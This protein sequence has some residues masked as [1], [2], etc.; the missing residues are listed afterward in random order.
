MSSNLRKEDDR[1]CGAGHHECLRGRWLNT[2]NELS[3]ALCV[4]AAKDLELKRLVLQTASQQVCLLHIHSFAPSQMDSVAPGALHVVKS[5]AELPRGSVESGIPAGAHSQVRRFQKRTA[6]ISELLEESAIQDKLTALSSDDVDQQHRNGS[7]GGVTS[8]MAGGRNCSQDGS[9]AGSVSARIGGASGRHNWRK[10][11]KA[12]VATKVLA[13]RPNALAQGRQPARQALAQQKQV[14]SSKDIATTS[15]FF[16]GA[17]ETP[18]LRIKESLSNALTFLAMRVVILPET[19]WYQVWWFYYAVAIAIVSCWVEPFQ[20]AFQHPGMPTA[21]WMTALEYV[22]IV[23]FLLDFLFKFVVAYFDPET[24]VLVTAQP[25]MAIAYCRSVKFFLDI[26]G[27]FPYDMLVSAIARRCGASNK[28]ED[29][30]DWLKLMALSRAYRVFDLFHVLDYRMML[31]QGTLMLLR[32]Y[33]YVFFTAHWAACIFFHMAHEERNYRHGNDDSWV[34]RNGPAFMGRPLY[35]QYILSLYFT[36]TIFTSMGDGRLY[37][38]TIV[39]LSV[40]IVYLLFNLFLGAYIIGTVTIMMVR[41][42]EHSKS[43]RDSMTHLV[44]Y[45]RENELPERLYKAMREHLEVHFD[46]AQTA[47]DNVLSIYPTTIRRLV[48]RHLYLQPVRSCYLFKGCKQRFLDALL[49]AARVE[50]FLP[51]VEIMTEGDNVVELLIVMLG[52]CLVSRGG[53]RVGGVYGMSTLGASAVGSDS[54]ISFLTGSSRNATSDGGGSFVGSAVGSKAEVSVNVR[55]GSLNCSQMHAGSATPLLSPGGVLLSPLPPGL[56][57]KIPNL[58]ST[59]KKGPSDALAEIAFFTDGASYETVVGRTPVRVLSLP[60][61]AW[62]LLVQQFPQQLHVALSLVSGKEFV[63]TTDPVL[64][65]QTRDALTHHQMEMIT[66]LDDIRTVAATHTR[67]C[68]EMRTF[69]F[70]NTAAQ[71]DVES[72]RTMLAQGISPNTADYDGRTGLMLAAAKGH[73]E[74]VQLLLDAGADKDKTD[75]FGISALAEAVKNEHDSTIE[76][77]LKYGATLGAGGLTVAAEMCT[78]VYEGDLVKLRRLLR[79]GAPPDACDYDKRSALH[80]AGAE[81]NLAAVKLLVEEGGADPNFQDRWGNTALDEARRVGAAPV[82]A[83]LEGRQKRDAGVT[84]E[85]KRQ[86]AAHEFMS[87]CGLGQVSELRNAGGY[88]FGDE[89]GCVFAGLLL[90]ASKGHTEVVEVLLEGMPSEVLWNHAHVAMMEAARMAHPDTVTAFRRAGVALCDP[91]GTTTATS[92]SCPSSGPMMMRS[93][94]ADLRAAAQQG[95]G[96]VL[97][98]LLAA[99][100]PGTRQPGDSTSPLHVAVEYGHLGVA[101]RLVEHGGAAADLLSLDGLGRTPLQVAE[102]LSSMRPHDL[103]AKAVHEYLVWAA[104]LAAAGTGPAALAAAAVEQWGPIGHPAID[105]HA[106]EVAALLG[107]PQTPSISGGAGGGGAGVKSSLS[108]GVDCRTDERLTLPSAL[109]ASCISRGS[110]TPQL[111]S[112]GGGGGGGASEAPQG[113]HRQPG[114]DPPPLHTV[115]E[116]CSGAV[117]ISTE[118]GNGNLDDNSVAA[119]AD[120]GA[121]AAAGGLV[122]IPSPELPTSFSV[123]D[124]VGMWD[125]SLP[126]TPGDSTRGGTGAGTLLAALAARRG[127]AEAAQLYNA[128]VQHSAVLLNEPPSQLPDAAGGIATGLPSP[129]PAASWLRRRSSTFSPVVEDEIEQYMAALADGNDTAPAAAPAAPAAAPAGLQ[130]PEAREALASPGGA[131]QRHLPSRLGGSRLGSQGISSAPSG[132][133]GGSG[134]S[135]PAIP[136]DGTGL[137]REGSGAAG[138]PLSPR[139]SLRS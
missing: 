52:E 49:T 4:T 120:G 100:V 84:A 104:P 121:A 125:S 9:E 23:T 21:V 116:E 25:K 27:C 119:G 18:W 88:S 11:N 41:A 19:S 75:A 69:E 34:G 127:P 17:R 94:I 56:P 105:P 40:M 136:G 113:P 128:T 107:T 87:W 102:H 78:A 110:N 74:T 12:V 77:M 91:G 64:L 118:T 39:E 46:S 60:K 139:G 54:N 101:R 55:D 30:V 135:S 31:S 72:L 108:P 53:Q 5:S 6:R 14:A 129:A 57:P 123:P 80:I 44:E 89:A 61:A 51:G 66:R 29:S 98:A 7:G 2:V 86:Q 8:S 131:A 112:G 28:I 24:G 109:R 1:D 93:L 96:T 43:F 33:T 65:A 115:V 37:P 32:N 111:G 95:S 45:S 16:L 132:R 97:E 117:S 71:G 133:A 3:T 114:T 59:L 92:A 38:F 83:Y 35:E 13:S 82:L 50:L 20:M 70:L 76:L 99:G 124:V 58:T 137:V 47:D 130:V 81:G 22:I 73:N 122:A 134:V 90:A 85:K 15:N 63:D 103:H 138:S 26:L 10:L 48:L 36:V 68:D 62:E 79:S 126:G 42:D 106:P 67:K